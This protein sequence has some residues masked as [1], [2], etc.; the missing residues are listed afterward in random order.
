MRAY[1]GIGS[2]DISDA[3]W[4]QIGTVAGLL[5]DRGWTCY[6]GNAPG[7][8][9]AFGDGAKG[10]LVVFLPW[11]GFEFHNRSPGILPARVWLDVGEDPDGQASV[12]QYH[13]A[14]RTLSKAARH[15]MARNAH[16][17]LGYQGHGHDFPTV[18]FVLCCATPLGDGHVKGGTGQAVR[19]ALDHSIPVFNLRTPQWSAELTA[20][21]EKHPCPNT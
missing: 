10:D 9:Q 5:A 6:S 8:D 17:V 4:V 18:S 14:P 13:P 20:F 21:L 2:R 15:F 7:A 11:W 3:E 19:I 16:Q 12:D 1:A